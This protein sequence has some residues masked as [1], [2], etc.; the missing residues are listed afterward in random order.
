MNNLPAKITYWGIPNNRKYPKRLHN[1]KK[2][3]NITPSFEETCRL[4]NYSPN[5]KCHTNEKNLFSTMAQQARDSQPA[6]ATVDGHPV[7]GP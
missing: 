5:I 4:G 1:P 7:R 2:T 6:S 3:G